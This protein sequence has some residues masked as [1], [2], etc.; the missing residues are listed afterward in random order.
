MLERLVAFLTALVVLTS[1]GGGAALPSATP[2]PSVAA[3]YPVTVVDYRGK[4]LTLAAAPT[5]IVSLAPSATEILFA[6]GAGDRIVATDDFSDYPAEA[7]A[8]PKIGGVRTSPEKVVALKPD[9]ILAITSGNLP[10]QLEAL[11]QPLFIFDPSDLDGV[12][13]N[14]GAVGRLVGR[15]ARAKE[16]VDDMRARISAISEKAKQAAAKPKVLHEV[17]STDPARIFVA[18]PRNFIDSMITLCGG[19]NVAA[20][21]SAKFPRLSA[22]EVIARAPDLIVLADF[23]FGTT[24]EMV[25]ARPGWSSIP[26]VRNRAIYPIDD[27]LVSR[28]GP[29]L[30]LGFEAYAKIVHPELFGKP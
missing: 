27:D 17:D 8:L 20:D 1:C 25:I 24:P 26:A 7:K 30:V 11:S 13:K 6:L 18:G 4:C 16:I 10:A 12:Y 28:P 22:E 5:R 15:D 19:T 21:A 23:R 29:R 2:A 3:A 14:V 9:L